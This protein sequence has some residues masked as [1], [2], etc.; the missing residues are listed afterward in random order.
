MTWSIEQTHQIIE[1]F[2]QNGTTRCPDDNGPL[3][4]KLHK[5]H[6]GDYDLMAECLFC[7]KSKNIRRADDP[8]R[9]QFRSWTLLETE[10]LMQIALD[11]A[12]AN[13]PVCG[14]LVEKQP[15][16]ASGRTPLVRCFRCG[17]SNQWQQVPSLSDPT[18][19]ALTG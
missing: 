6:G 11:K 7:G 2:W 4:L 3:K 16:S 12:Q 13:C 10:H 8:R 1:Q 15:A 17:N 14:A 9:S 18:G 5:L 19:A